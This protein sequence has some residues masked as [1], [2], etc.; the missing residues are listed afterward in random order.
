MRFSER[1]SINERTVAQGADGGFD[2]FR[3]SKSKDVVDI[4][5]NTLRSYHDDGL[6]FYR[7][8]KAVFVSRVELDQ[9]IRNPAIFRK[10][11][12]GR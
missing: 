9:F 8:G 12:G 1:M 2:L 10:G 11:K 3:L 7:R 5:A 4:C 6:P